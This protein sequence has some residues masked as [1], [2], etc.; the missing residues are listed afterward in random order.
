MVKNSFGGSGAKKMGR[1]FQGGGG[2]G[3]NR[4]LRLVEDE[5]EMYAA[6]T[7]MLGNGMCEVMCNDANKRLC[8]IR[9][10]FRGRGKRDNTVAIGTWLMVGERSWESGAGGG[11]GGSAKLQKCDLLE[12]YN[13]GEK[14]KLKKVNGIELMLLA[15]DMMSG[16]AAAAEVGANASGYG[17]G[18]DDLLE[19]SNVD[20]SIIENIVHEMKQDVDD[21]VVKKIITDDE[22]NIISIDD[23]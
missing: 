7:K 22:N 9:N 4:A 6:V 14:Q 19:F 16:A 21:G 10:K 23:I 1:K 8:I 15:P 18:L 3:G 2:G 12:V 20:N 13:D 11:A 17:D 5:D